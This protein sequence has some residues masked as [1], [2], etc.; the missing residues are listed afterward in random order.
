MKSGFRGWWAEA[1]RLVRRLLQQC[2]QESWTRAVI[3]ALG[4]LD[5]HDDVYSLL[6]KWIEVKNRMKGSSKFLT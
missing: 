1:G 6:K 3:A 2:E 4:K 5:I